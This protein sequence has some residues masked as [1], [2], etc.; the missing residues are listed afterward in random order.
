MPTTL[1]S[2]VQ[3][4]LRS[5][6]LAR[7]TRAEYQT[8]LT[9]WREWGGG[10]PIERLGRKEIRE[11]LNWVYDRARQRGHESGPH[12][13]QSPRASAGGALVG[14]GARHH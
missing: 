13:E 5:A 10:V 2:A 1:K 14:L 9:K 4:Y 12:G 7:G 11:F 3:K 6:N 8:T